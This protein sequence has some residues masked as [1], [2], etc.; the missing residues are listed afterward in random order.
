MI[1]PAYILI[2]TSAYCLLVMKFDSSFSLPPVFYGGCQY[3][4]TV[5]IE[6]IIVNG[7]LT[8][9]QYRIACFI[10]K[11]WLGKVCLPKLCRF[12][13]TVHVIK[14]IRRV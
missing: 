8:L 4:I 11:F 14:A 3:I 9:Y 12:Y 5:K 7:I 2:Y 6:Y 13:F 1:S 10:V